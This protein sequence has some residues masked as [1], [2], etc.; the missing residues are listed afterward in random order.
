MKFRRAEIWVSLS[1][2]LALAFPCAAQEQAVTLRATQDVQLI[3]CA[4]VTSIPCF[5]V[6]LTPAT[7]G[8]ASAPVALPPKDRLLDSIRIDS[9]ASSVTPF[10]VSTGSGP[11]SATQTRVVLIE[12]DISGSMNQ[13]VAAGTTRIAAARSAI[14]AYL[15]SMQDSIDHVAIVPFESHNVIATIRSAVF[16]SKRSEALAQLK[17]LPDPKAENN[18]ALYQ[19]VFSGVDTLQSEVNSLMRPGESAADFSPTLIVMT[20]GKNDLYRGDD[21]VLL[22][23]PLGL[24]Q[25]AAKV[26]AA[27]FDVIGIGFGEPSEIDTEALSKLSTRQYIATDPDQLARAFRAAVPLHT[28]E[29]Q[30]AFLSPWPDPT[31]LAA[32]DTAFTLSL[33]LPGGRE[34]RSP[35]LRY[36]APAMG[37]PI[38][39]E[40]A[41]PEVLQAL[42]ASRPP[43]SSGWEVLVRDLLIFAGFSVL[44]LCLW[45][46]VPR[47]I[48]PN[49]ALIPAP[50]RSRKWGREQSVQA[51]G[52]QV[53]TN[54]PRGFEGVPSP[55][56]QQR[57]PSQITQ[58]QPRT[59]V[60]SRV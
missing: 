60:H 27:G 55:E 18:T 2:A 20:D 13:Q 4:P 53:R 29:V 31:L 7:T 44:L 41:S 48:W 8:G 56:H 17:A 14:A 9:R 47:L 49:D 58:V 12:V 39:V 1:A 11:G 5:R 16:S 24:Q 32:Q 46:W 22:D 59:E 23:G 57:L 10:Y 54:V 33:R 15:G 34:L 45:F 51:S 21:A 42:I 35:A 43:A 25:A 37:T 38:P 6:A 30:A 28:A 50:S 19:A 3:D 40:R 52:M 26:R 36:I